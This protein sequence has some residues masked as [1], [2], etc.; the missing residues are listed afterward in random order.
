METLED[1][2]SMQIRTRNDIKFTPDFRISVQG[3]TEDGIHI[4]VHPFGYNGETI[5]YKVRGDKLTSFP[6]RI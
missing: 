4:L 2:L 6:V 3:K 1:L 5:S